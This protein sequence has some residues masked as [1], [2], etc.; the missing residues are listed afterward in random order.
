MK[1]ILGNEVYLNDEV[2]HV[3]V[4]RSSLNLRKGIV[5]E[6]KEGDGIK[7]QWTEFWS[8]EPKVNP[9]WYTRFILVKRHKTCLACGN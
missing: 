4:S 8:V 5:V 7:M 1:D 2:A 6:I 3:V 9:R